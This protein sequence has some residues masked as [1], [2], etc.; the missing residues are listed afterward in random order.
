MLGFLFGTACLVG[1]FWMLKR[2]HHGGACGHGPGRWHR[3]GRGHG[4][5]SDHGGWGERSGSSWMLRWLFERLDTTP[6]QEKVIRSAFEELAEK[7][8]GLKQ[9]LKDSKGDVARAFRADDFNA[10]IFGDVFS[11]HDSAMDEMRKA[12][13]G[14]FA[15]VHDVLDPAQRARLAELLESMPGRSWRGGPYRSWA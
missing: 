15:K 4:S 6:G 11:R 13:V 1:L 5:W 12:V 2:G 7:A 3:G 9:T 10:E 14:A 8:R